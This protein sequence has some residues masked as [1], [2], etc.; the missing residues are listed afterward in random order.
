MKLE[1]ISVK[2]FLLRTKVGDLDLE[3][4][5]AHVIENS[6]SIQKKY[7]PFITL[8]DKIQAP[9]KKGKLFG[10]PISVKD[11]IC[12]KGMQTTA[13][14]KILEGYIPPFSATCVDNIMNE[15]GVIL[16]K[17]AM[18][19]FG[20]GTFSI[21][22]AYG[23]PK[24][25]LDTDRSCGGSSGG[26]S[27]ITAAADFPHIALAESTGGSISCPAAFTGTVGLT[28]TYGLVSRW[29]LIDYANSLDKIGC[30]GKSVY[31]VALL[32]SVIAG[33]DPR[34]STSLNVPK[35]DYTKFLKKDIKGMKIGV[36]EEYFE[37]VDE[38]ITKVVWDAIKKLEDLGA[39]Y[40]EISLPH[41]KYSL[42]A[43][44]IIA[45][46]EASTNLAKYCGM[47]YGLHL[48][49]Q[50]NFDEYF[51]TVRSNGFGEE[52]KRRI[53]LGTFARMAGYRDAYYLK[54]L[55]VRTKVIE[56]FKKA[57]KQFDVLA[58]PTM[59]IVAPRFDE[60][61]KLSPIEV[62]MMDIL[63]VAPNLAG[64]PMISVPAGKVGGLPVGLHLMSDYLQEGKILQIA[65]AFCL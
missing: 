35:E 2:E 29:G 18:D 62:Y 58:A 44:Y 64:I 33:N 13:G 41:T 25:P 46:S 36:P 14:S 50:G 5:S 43:Y 59:P 28:P 57:F 22:C 54:A 40:E 24:N 20:F 9:Q 30:I 11:N 16:G 23:I 7:N 3:D 42:P 32:L 15:G 39:T 56:D 17:T 51:S 53:I 55:K 27:C 31:D 1:K 61:E 10:L 52:A 6:R 26:A 19:E 63:T 8:K 34:D 45:V 49:L 12:T 65:N 21:N 38:K 48:Q 4:F 60:I 47:R 37:G